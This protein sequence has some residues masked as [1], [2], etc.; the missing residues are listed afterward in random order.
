VATLVLKPGE[1]GERNFRLADGRHVIGRAEDNSIYVRYRNLSRRHAEIEVQGDHVVVRDLGSKNGTFVNGDRVE[2]RVLAFGDLLACGSAS[3]VLQKG[4]SVTPSAIWTVSPPTGLGA[5]LSTGGKTPS[6]LRLSSPPGRRAEDKLRVLLEVS[7]MLA[8]PVDLDTL[9]TR[10]LDVTFQILDVSRGAVLLADEETH[11]LSPRIVRGAAAGEAAYSTSVVGWVRSTGQ[12]AL[13]ADAMSDPRVAGAVSLVA[14]SIRSSMCAPLRVQSGLLGVLYV[15][16]VAR[17]GRFNQEDLE[18][19]GA[20]ATQAAMAIESARLRDRIEREAVL[21]SNLVR[22]FPPTAVKRLAE[23][24]AAALETAD[25]EVTAL[26]A[27]ITGFT[28]LSSALPP[29]Q[30]VEILNEYFP[31]MSEIVFRHEGTLEKYIG[32]ALMA[33]WGAPFSHDDDADRALRAAVDMQRAVRELSLRLEASLGRPLKIHVGVH[34]GPVAAG[35]IGSA[36][37]LQFATIGD[38]TNVAARLCAVAEADEILVS[39]ATRARARDPSWMVESLPPAQVKG[40]PDPVPVHRLS[41]E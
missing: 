23:A 3:F 31:L 7:Q 41:W 34:S 24:S 38:T 16:N 15:D 6:A 37:Y 9:L 12:A 26:F 39:D 33:V 18:F 10:I 1:P 28:E 20:F 19:L 2:Q 30:V 8:A 29:R 35:N 21:R 27:D 4:P 22:F 36:T 17:P 14:S 13:F 11:D 5:L 40:K 32:D 25:A